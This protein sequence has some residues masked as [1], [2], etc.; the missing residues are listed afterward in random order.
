MSLM[1]K[2]ENLMIS[3]GDADGPKADVCEPGV[4]PLSE[5]LDAGVLL[6]L[7]LLKCNW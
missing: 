1:Q 7:H 4:T 6:W 2:I 5:D 3:S